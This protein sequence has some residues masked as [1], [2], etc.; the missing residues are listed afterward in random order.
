MGHTSDPA[1]IPTPAQGLRACDMYRYV[2]PMSIKVAD[3]TQFAPG[4]KHVEDP[5]SL[6]RCLR[7]LEK[8]PR[9]ALSRQDH[10]VWGKP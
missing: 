2:Q 10:H 7:F 8:H 6:E 4:T 1:F 5:A 3:V 9:W